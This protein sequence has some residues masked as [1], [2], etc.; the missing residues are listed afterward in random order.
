MKYLVFFLLVFSISCS[1]VKE[2]RGVKTDTGREDLKLSAEYRQELSQENY[3]FIDLYFLNLSEDW[4]RLKQV[5]VVGVNNSEIFHSILGSDLDLWLKSM[6]LDFE[7]KKMNQLMPLREEALEGE[8]TLPARLQT[9]R[10]LLLQT[11]KKNLL[12][13]FSLEVIFLNS[14]VKVYPIAVKGVSL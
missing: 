6:K 1:S 3:H 9:K 2:L 8:L 11:P 12:E 13:G 5:R 14:E 7:L 10:W 4:Q